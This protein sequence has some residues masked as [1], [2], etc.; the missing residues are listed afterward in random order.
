V[1]KLRIVHV[2]HLVHPDAGGPPT[3]AVNLA[4]AQARL[5]HTVT[6]LGHY[7]RADEATS[8]AM[9][10]HV[11]FHVSLKRELFPLRTGFAKF[12]ANDFRNAL[13]RLLP[14]TNILIAHGVWYAETVHGASMAHRAGVPYVVRPAGMLDPWSLRQKPLK[15]MIGLRLLYGNTLRNAAF[16]HATTQEEARNIQHVNDRCGVSVPIEVIPNGIFLK[17][18]EFPIARGSFYADHPGLRGRPYIAFLGRLHRKKRADLLIQAFV[19]IAPRFPDLQLVIAG[20]D[21]GEAANLLRL[22]SELKM[23]ERIHFTGPIYGPKKFEMLADATCFCLPSEGE[24]FGVA[25]AEAMAAGTAVV[26]S[27]QVQIWPE[28][29]QRRAGKTCKLDVK[30]VATT[31]C[32][33]LQDEAAR[34]AM[35][36]AGRELTR[37]MFLW[38]NIAIRSTERYAEVLLK[39]SPRTLNAA[40]PVSCL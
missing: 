16:V 38:R 32:D 28:I 3:V 13:R 4:A 27:D 6:V 39:R 22:S 31:L 18:V 21:D 19:E 34:V 25:V 14:E 36:Q 30:S 10:D 33:V 1:D 40:P 12:R 26:V 29:E 35:G 5:G 24:N 8:Q 11:P 37:D 7:P 15:K 2:T 17:D 20:P 9:F 23:N